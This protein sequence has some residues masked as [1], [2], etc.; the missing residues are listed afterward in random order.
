[1]DRWP[2]EEFCASLTA[3]SSATKD[4][5]ARD[6]RAFEQWCSDGFPPGQK[7]EI[8]AEVSLRL[9]QVDRSTV[10]NYLAHLGNEQYARATM[11]RKLSSL[12]R[13]F[14]WAV[15]TQ[16]ISVDPTIGIHSGKAASRL[17]R[18]LPNSEIDTLIDGTRPL[19]IEDD[20]DRQLRDR[21]VI[22][23]LYGSGLRVSE[24]CALDV[25]DLD[26][27]RGAVRVMGK[28][29]KERITP[30]TQCAVEALADYLEMGRPDWLA[31]RRGLD[32]PPDALFF[33]LRGRRIGPRDV[34]RILDRRAEQPTHPHAL[35]HSFATHLL[36][37]GADLRAVQELLGHEELATTQIYTH[38]S[39]QRLKSSIAKT[40]PRG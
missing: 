40:H 5:Y 19:V 37:G 28:G 16:Q 2:V 34:R 9:D 13:F 23:I 15:R 4:V 11:N 10:R 18:V 3:V 20:A 27:K 33:N 25:D 6:I 36:D 29:Q 31:A 14:R 12:R 7:A 32:T 8:T 30:L 35:R 26:L 1:M 39:K 21:A 38:V 17:P 22:E 24:L